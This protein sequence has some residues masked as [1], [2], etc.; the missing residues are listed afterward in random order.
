MLLASMPPHRS[1][2]NE[3]FAKGE[4]E[5]C[6]HWDL[7]HST[8]RAHEEQT[9]PVAIGISNEGA[10]E[11]CS[12]LTSEASV[13]MLAAD[14]NAVVDGRRDESDFRENRTVGGAEN[15]GESG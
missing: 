5:Q 8:S 15:Q 7:F 2:V 14:A 3:R 6:P 10:T 1:K 13:P 9:Q 11:G 4:N 12:F